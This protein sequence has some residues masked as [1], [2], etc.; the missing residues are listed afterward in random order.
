MNKSLE[1]ELVLAALSFNGIYFYTSMHLS[2]AQSYLF[3]FC[4][5]TFKLLKLT[6]KNSPIKNPCIPPEMVFRVLV[7]PYQESGI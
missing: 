1:R 5:I 6:S 2:P 4:Y 3:L 7:G